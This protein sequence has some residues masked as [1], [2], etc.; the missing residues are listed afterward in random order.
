M[1]FLP[2]KLLA[3]LGFI[4]IYITWGTTYLAIAITLKE[5]P[6]FLMSATRFLVAAALLLLYC[7]YKKVP[8][9]FTKEITQSA[10]PGLLMLVGGTA[11][12]AWAEQHVPS[13]IAAITNTIAP[14]W[15]VLLDKKQ[16]KYYFSSKWIIIG[17][18]TGFAGT[19]LLL[20]NSSM[21][22]GHS[23]PAMQLTRVLVLVFGCGILWA[24]G[25][26]Y[27]KYRPSNL[28][29]PANICIQL[30]V[31]GIVC[32]MISI[33]SE[34]VSINRFFHLGTST[35]LALSYLVVM[36]NIVA[37]MVYLWLLKIKP[38]A[39]VSTYAYVSPVIAVI[40]GWLIEGDKI[41]T[42]QLMSFSII[43]MGVM[44]LNLPKYK[45][46]FVCSIARFPLLKF[47]TSLLFC[48]LS[49]VVL[50]Q[51]IQT[52]LP[53]N[54]KAWKHR[55]IMIQ[56]L[57]DSL[58]NEEAIKLDEMIIPAGAMDTILHQ[59]TAHLIGFILEGE[60]ITKMKNKPPQFLKTGQAFYEFPDEIHE[61]IKNNSQRKQARILLYYLYNK[62]AALY[63]TAIE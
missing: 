39:V 56:T 41:T 59:H 14:F 52:P 44:F 11:V 23:S 60:I 18:L 27:S 15:F 35:W 61:Y 8:F 3:I 30:L 10:L 21:G 25:S 9:P 37:Y 13:G 1:K 33:P 31:A 47:V 48:I 22:I 6:P 46:A 32:L 5:L 40:A 12:I 38:P 28:P 2:Q 45:V 42:V 17:L 36:G 24:G 54:T 49:V 34:H 51:T 58:H 4:T 16:W 43:L 57:E 62:N 7:N 26:L 53:Q 29:S 20:E 50:S 55:L 19:V 63:K